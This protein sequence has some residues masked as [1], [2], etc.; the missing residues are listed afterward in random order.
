M[1]RNKLV[2]VYHDHNRRTMLVLKNTRSMAKVVR[3]VVD[4]PMTIEQISVERVASLFTKLD[5]YPIEKAAANYLEFARA[6]G[7]STEAVDA[8]TKFCQISDQWRA[9]IELQAARSNGPSGGKDNVSRKRRRKKQQVDS[10]K[11]KSAA[12]MFRALIAEGVLDD[13]EIFAKVQ[14]E[15]GLANNRRSYVSYYRRQLEKQNAEN[16]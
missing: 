4:R 16:A 14:A 6:T 2:G 13:D 15:F 5:D 12:Q 10:S 11:Y 7:A 3:L 9:D 1:R 8:L